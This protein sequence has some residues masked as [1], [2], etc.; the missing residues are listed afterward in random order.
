MKKNDNIKNNFTGVYSSD[1][2]NKYINFHK[3]LKTNKSHY[4]FVILNTSRENKP[5]VHW[6]SIINIDPIN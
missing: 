2:I 3:I 1:T 5:G 6:W 4:P